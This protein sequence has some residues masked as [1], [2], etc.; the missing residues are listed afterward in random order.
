[1]LNGLKPACLSAVVAWASDVCHRLHLQPSYSASAAGTR[2]PQEMILFK[3]DATVDSA[4]DL[5]MDQWS[6]AHG[7]SGVSHPIG[8]SAAKQH[9]WDKPP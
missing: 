9:E 3:C 5:I 7:Q 6:V 8:P 2:D 4:V 1:M